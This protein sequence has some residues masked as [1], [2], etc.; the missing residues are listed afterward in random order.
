[1]INF[2]ALLIFSQNV[3]SI[4]LTNELKFDKSQIEIS[5]VPLTENMITSNL[6]LKSTPEIKLIW[7]K[8]ESD[9]HETIEDMCKF[10]QGKIIN[11]KLKNQTIKACFSKNKDISFKTQ[12]YQKSDLSNA[13]RFMFKKGIDK[14]NIIKFFS[15]VNYSPE[16][17]RK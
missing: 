10:D 5:E 8:I 7:M 17:L 6:T 1:M 13:H 4:T 11:L 3:F 14:N 12:I 9:P 15:Y 2:L 16:K